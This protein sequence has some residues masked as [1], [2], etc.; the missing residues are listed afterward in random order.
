MIMMND[1]KPKPKGM[2]DV[3]GMNG[4]CIIMIM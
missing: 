4:Y 1:V 2:D 3:K